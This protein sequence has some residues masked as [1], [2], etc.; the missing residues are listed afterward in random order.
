MNENGRFYNFCVAG[1]HSGTGKTTITLGLLTA[2]AQRGL[3]VQPFKCGPDYIDPGHHRQACGLVSRNLDT[4]MM[5]EDAVKTSYFRALE[6][7]DVA[8]TEGVMGLFDGASST[9]ITGSTAHVCKV[10][11]IPIVLVVD[12]RSM[13]RSV[14]A[15]VKGF[16]DF[17]EGV[18]IAAV[19]ANRVG[20]E[21]HRK[22]LAESLNATGLPPL[23]GAIPNDDDIYT[24]E[25]HLGLVAATENRRADEWYANLA[26]NMENYIDIEKLLQL[27]SRSLTRTEKSD[28]QKR[29]VANPGEKVNARVGIARDDAFHFY[30][31]DNLDI[32]REYGAEL[33][34][35][36]PLSDDALPKNL[37][38]LYIGGGFPECFAADLTA[39][40]AMREAIRSFAAAGGCVYAECGGFMY[41]CKSLT[42]MDGK[43]YQMCDI[44]P[45]T[46]RMEERRHRLGYLEARTLHDGFFGGP[47]AVLRGHEFHW[48]SC[49]TKGDVEPAFSARFPR[50]K[51]QS[52]DCSIGLHRWNVWGSY[53]HLHFAS[54]PGACRA[55]LSGMGI[56][57]RS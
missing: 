28:V 20:S 42:D 30:Y 44:L 17:E 41:L 31:E 26:G 54:N 33:I 32:M 11:N 13:A 25:R 4:W 19:I 16:N 40:E 6:N 38:G 53:A 43:I 9:A 35:F 52:E 3:R 24:P 37:D 56:A 8:V 50:R 5:G 45:A 55:W 1:T 48:S 18:R 51:K 22:I 57:G 7:A 34:P 2:L 14:A 29:F 10:L 36:S 46:T 21:G 39:N 47:G 15:L 49:Q 12:A 27:S 23:V